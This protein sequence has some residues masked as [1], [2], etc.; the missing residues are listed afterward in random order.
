MWS[1]N[2][3]FRGHR[4]DAHH[5]LNEEDPTN[6][7]N[8][9]EILKYGAR[10]GNLMDVLFENCPSN[11]TYRSKTIQN[12]IINICGEL[13]TEKIVEEIKDAKFF[14]VL[15]DEA[16]DCSN[17]EQ[18]A[19]VLRFVD[20]NLKVREEFLGFISCMKGLSGEALSTE[21]KNFIQSVGLRMEEC[22][23]QRYDSAGNMAD[24]FFGVA[25]RILRSYE[26]AV[27]V[28]CGSRI[29]NLCVA[30]GCRI[31]MVR[32][33][34]DDVCSV[35][36]FFNNSP[37][38]TLVLKEK[39]KEIYPESHHQKLFNV[40]RTRWMAR[41]NGLSIFRKVYL[42]I[43]AALEVVRTDKS[44]EYDM[45]Y[46]AGGMIK[47]IKSFEFIV[48][49]VVVERCLE[50]TKPLTLQLQSASLDAGKAREKVSLLYLTIN[51]LRSDVD[52]VHQSYY[53]MAVELAEGGVKPLKKRTSDRQMHRNNV[54]AD[55][56]AEYLKR[57]LTIPFLDQLV[58]Q[59]QSRFSEGNLHVFDAMYALPSY[60]TSEPKWAEY[61]SRFL[62]KYQDDLPSPDFLE[63][64]LRMWNIFCM[65]AKNPLPNSIQELLPFI[66]CY[67][68]PN[69]LTALKI[70]GTIP[71]T[72]CSCERSISTLHRLKTFMRSTMGEKRLTS[73]PLLNVHREIHLDIEKVI[74]RFALK[75]PRRMVLV[76]ILNI[77][78][79]EPEETPVVNE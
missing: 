44:N 42:A 9:I 76:D 51:E 63:M 10:C 1:P 48:S 64:E 7:G 53:E 46:K 3:A 16:T 4:D 34:M 12:E 59:I 41:I 65:N 62:D 57:A 30:S 28:H 58:G 17:V 73:L 29:L 14:T 26:K 31:E 77:D 71:V 69:I 78:D 47:A 23:G 21:I 50:C 33:M 36:D 79:D 2:L 22:R 39:I 20:N 18:M 35:S 75:H 25:A 13:I 27:Y 19:I 45:C 15:A 60:V 68:F 74:D 70:F 5:Y 32:K 67:S 72:T 61:F 24:K 37:K 38:R 49:L 40:C 54:P 52:K 56:T 11:Q 6:P 8:F 66:D 55:C 43:L